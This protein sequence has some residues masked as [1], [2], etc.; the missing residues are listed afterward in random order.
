MSHPPDNELLLLAYGELPVSRAV[1]IETHTA[2]C[3]ACR[4]TLAL[5]ERGRVALDVAMPA[6]RRRSAIVWAAAALAA[7]ALLAG[8]VITRTGSTR[9][10]AERWT[11]ITTWSATAG[12]VTGGQVMMDI[13][14]QLTRLER[15][16]YYGQPN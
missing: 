7:A 16:R 8:I 15:E 1:E 13:D 9:E 2:N 5:I 12:Y 14:A 10:T 3:P 11:P 6:R 4:E